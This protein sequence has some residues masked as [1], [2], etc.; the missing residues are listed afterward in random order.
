MQQMILKGA[1]DSRGGETEAQGAAADPDQNQGF[2][3]PSSHN[4]AGKSPRDTPV[5]YYQGSRPA[6]SLSYSL[7]CLFIADSVKFF[8]FPSVRKK[9]KTLPE[10]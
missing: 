9:K 3:W 5:I 8:F 2:I 7:T 6:I 4:A 10:A 1:K